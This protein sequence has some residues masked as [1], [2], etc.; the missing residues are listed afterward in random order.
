MTTAIV[1]GAGGT[2]RR[3]YEMIKSFVSVKAFVDNDSGKWGG[4]YDGIQISNPE[5]LKTEKY[6]VI[7]LGT[8]MGLNEVQKQLQEFNVPI[9]K[10]DKTY[11][12]ISV[13][14]RIMFIK[15]LAERFRKE[16]VQ[17]SVAEAGVFRGEFA[18]EINTYFPDRKCYLFDT[19]EGFDKRDFGYEEKPS[20][21]E[22]ANHLRATSE[23]I[24]YNKMPNKE[25][26][27]IRKGYF[28]E[29]TKEIEDTFAFVNL[30]MDLYQPTIEGLKFFYP[31]MSVGGVILIHDYF[32]EIYPNVE[33]SVD[34][35]E[36]ESGIRLS[37]IPIGDD[38][39]IAII[40][41]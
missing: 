24:V 20:M 31:R 18:K 23:D 34:D 8:L 36:K 19:F 17:G 12:E 30:D 39:S 6:D 1:F 29:T 21:T 41:V 35:F 40:K 32:T 10:L 15:R 13:K 14:S 37:K 16:E 28:P 33:K 5:I 26:V 2:G 22:E 11:V 25:M 3:V 27:E 9:E 4:Y 38:I 7:Y